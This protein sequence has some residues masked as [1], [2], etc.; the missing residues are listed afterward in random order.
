MSF[1]VLAEFMK[2]DIN[3]NVLHPV[4][5]VLNVQFSFHLELFINDIQLMAW[6]Y[7][8][9]SEQMIALAELYINILEREVQITAYF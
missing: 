1:L 2:A 9:K 7:T 5:S 6:C 3:I 8:V 4:I